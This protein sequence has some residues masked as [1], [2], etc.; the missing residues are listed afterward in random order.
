MFLSILDVEIDQ[1]SEK[2]RVLNVAV[3]AH[4]LVEKKM[5]RAMNALKKIH[6]RQVIIVRKVFRPQNEVVDVTFPHMGIK[7]AFQIGKV[8]L[9][10]V[11]DDSRGVKISCKLATELES[12]VFSYFLLA[13]RLF[14]SITNL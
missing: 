6:E 12:V 14:I 10:N 9:T 5:E 11:K 7:I 4:A 8:E 3:E 13:I 1:L 2:R